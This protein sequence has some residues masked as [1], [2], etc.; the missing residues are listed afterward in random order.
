MVVALFLAHQAL[1]VQVGDAVNLRFGIRNI[2]L[3]LL[4]DGGI[5]HRNGECT[6]GRIAVTLRFDLIQHHRGAGSAVQFNALAHNLTQLFL[7]HFEVDFVP[8][9]AV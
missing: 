2:L 7:A 8:Q 6:A 5:A 4:G 1:C 9:Q 3:F